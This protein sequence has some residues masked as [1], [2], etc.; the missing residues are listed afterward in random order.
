MEAVNLTTPHW[1]TCMN[2]QIAIF[3]N[4]VLFILQVGHTG[5][6]GIFLCKLK[7]VQELW[8]CVFTSS[9]SQ[10]T[11]V[12]QYTEEL[13][14]TLFYPLTCQWIH[15]GSETGFCLAMNHCGQCLEAVIGG[16]GA[17]QVIFIIVLHCVLVG[18]YLFN[19]IGFVSV[20]YP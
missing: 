1:W 11:S 3:K 17:V 10:L 15:R 5:H 20:L 12:K 13:L 6:V 19:V 2:V 16:V 8:V 4:T 9:P 7:Y 14:L 18:L